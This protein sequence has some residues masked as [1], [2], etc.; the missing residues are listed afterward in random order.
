MA[1]DTDNLPQNHP[2]GPNFTQRPWSEEVA[3]ARA[4]AG[5]TVTNPQ[6]V[7]YVFSNGRVFRDPQRPL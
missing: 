4:N 1:A 6:E 3:V 7:A 5:E 2:G